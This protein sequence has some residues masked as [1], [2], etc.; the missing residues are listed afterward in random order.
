MRARDEDGKWRFLLQ[1]RSDGTWGM[2]GGTL[3]QGEDPWKGALRETTE[4]LGKLPPLKQVRTFHHVEDDGQTQVYLYL[5]EVPYFHPALDGAT[6]EETLGAAWFRRREVG[7]L[8][9]APK[10]REDWEKGISLREHV[11]KAL[12][13]MVNENGETLTLTPASQALQAVGSRWPYPHR[14]DGSEW[15]DSGPGN[16]AGAMGASEPPH[17]DDGA[18]LEPHG[19]AE[20]RGGDDGKMPARGRKPAPPAR[21]FPGQGTEHDEMWPQPQ[22]TLQPGVLSA[23]ADTGIPPSGEKQAKVSKE[24]V[25]YRDGSR[26]R[27]CGNCVMFHGGLCDL[28]AGEISALGVCDEW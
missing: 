4:E 13:R 3:H 2:P 16:A 10:F 27:H 1:Q 28:V 7:D 11:T 8:D 5:C 9:L 25:H 12:Q 18:E 26:Q 15:P 19:E 6:P 22:A 21:V 14:A 20:P 17:W 23:G 24:S